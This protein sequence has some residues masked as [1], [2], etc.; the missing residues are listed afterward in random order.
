V[1]VP[2]GSLG[3]V[4]SG[5][6]FAVAGPWS[7]QLHPATLAVVIAAIA[8][9]VAAARGEA[10]PSTKQRWA[11]AGAMVSVLVVGSWPLEDLAA[12][13]S[14]TALVIQRLL[15]FL[16]A[17]PMLLLSVPAPLAARLTRPRGI[18][19]VLAFVSKPVVAV[20]IFTGVAIGTLLVGVVAAQSSSS[21]ARA[22]IDVLLLLSGFVLWSPVVTTL[23]GASRPS[24][25]GR[26]VYL[27]VQSI[28]PG[29]PSVVFIFAHHP[30]YPGF[31][32][33]HAALGL[34]PLVDQ[35]LAGIVAK[36]ATLPVL[37]SAAWISLSKAHL[38]DREGTETE[39]L[40]WAEVQRQLER[41]ER[42]ERAGHRLA[43]SV[44]S[45]PEGAGQPDSGQPP[46]NQPPT[47]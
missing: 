33:V 21:L 7:P 25:L 8:F 18:D 16:V 5:Q 30:L 43:P 35:Q 38:F 6:V 2:A 26:A 12:H 34:S 24:H 39:P 40:T 44:G 10:R 13:W 46:L 19:S 45:G 1:T 37:W 42:A 28:V 11:F 32:H 14:L 3:A 9:Y 47:T 29:F 17:A 31:S 4:V 41:V 15:L 20:V 22:G 36:V 23:P 27:F